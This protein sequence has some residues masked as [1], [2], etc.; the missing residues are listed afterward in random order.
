MK[1]GKITFDGV[2]VILAPME[3]VSELPFRI[4]CKEM[5][6]DL[7][8]SEFIASEG[9]IRDAEKSIIKLR[10]SEKERPIAIQI[11]GGETDS[12][13]KA[14]EKALESNPDIIDLNCGCPVKKVVNKGGG[15]AM[16]RNPDKMV[17]A[18]GEIVK[19]CG[20]IP[21][22]VKTRIGWDQDSINIMDIALRLQDVGISALTI[23]GR[24]RC[25]MYTGAADWNVIASVKNN[26]AITIPIIG[27]GDIDS[28]EKAKQCL[29]MSHVDGLMIGR[30]AI[31]NP[32]IF[33]Q[34]KAYLKDG[35]IIAPPSI[36]QRVEMCRRHILMS[37]DYKGE[38][39]SILE[40]RHHYGCYFRAIRNFKPFKME[41]MKAM[42]VD[43]LLK[44]L[45]KIIS[46]NS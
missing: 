34:I 45:D 18:A 16:L 28:G 23:H 3:D 2:P 40:M 29:D 7:V 20:D 4:L 43:E 8:F 38:K 32:W 6:A 31:G 25:Q 37:V 22:T 42:S 44:I 46:A 12:L 35:S 14:A 11:F 17:K 21:V 27:N 5:G 26:P 1:T 36:E 10:I 24:T 13:V 41:L 33:N 19:V 30:A 15:A 9:L 39:R